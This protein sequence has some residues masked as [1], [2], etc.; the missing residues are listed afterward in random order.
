MTVR[1]NP[2]RVHERARGAWVVRDAVLG[3]R[4][5]SCNQK[6]KFPDFPSH[7]HDPWDRV[8]APCTVRTAADAE[9]VMKSYHRR[10]TM[11]A[12]HRLQQEID[13]HGHP[14]HP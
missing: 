11:F 13:A 10:N 3:Y 8:V 2:I 12:L 5:C 6:Y 7:I 9:A 14:H 4:I 1:R